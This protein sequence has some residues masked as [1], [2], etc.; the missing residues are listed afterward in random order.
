MYTA[1][2]GHFS[3][4]RGKREAER[5][6]NW[7]VEETQ[8]LLCAW[9]DERVQKSLS[10]NLRNKH[11]FKHLSARMSSLGF[12]RSPHQCRLRVKT[13]KANYVRAKLL[14]SV[15]GGQP[16][17]FRYYAEMD[18]VLGKA[19]SV[20]P[21]IHVSHVI[22]E[23]KSEDDR[24]ASTDEFEFSNPGFSQSLSVEAPPVFMEPHIA[25][26]PTSNSC[27]EAM[28][29]EED[30]SSNTPTPPPPPPAHP[31]SPPAADPSRPPSL[32]P[33]LRYLTDCF[34][35]LLW[36]WRRLMEQL[37]AQ[38]HE[39]ARWQQELLGRW[40]EQ[41][42]RRE[43]EVAEREARRERARMDHELRVLQLL[44]GL[45]R[46]PPCHCPHQRDPSTPTQHRLPPRERSTQEG[47]AQGL[48]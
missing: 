40:L 11:V 31:S 5:S 48:E 47:S 14:R 29:V 28:P 42:E 23:V 44:T 1:R 37:E 33:A 24:E 46:P 43:Q 7:S 4:V 36:E 12:A 16:C 27:H 22:H 32:D 21:G 6:V 3:H 18:A 30:L 17:T 19:R 35:R 38:R 9:S 10:E 41:Q 34:Q 39:Q 26:V 13:L 25:S 45:Q 2:K 8:A 20:E 15:D